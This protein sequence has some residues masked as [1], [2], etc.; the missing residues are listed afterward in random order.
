MFARYR[1]SA[2]ATP[3]TPA[4]TPADTQAAKPAATPGTPP[5]AMARKIAHAQASAPDRASQALSPQSRLHAPGQSPGGQADGLDREVAAWMARSI[6]ATNGM[7]PRDRVL[8]RLPE[9]QLAG[10]LH[11]YRPPTLTLRGRLWHIDPAR[12]ARSTAVWFAQSM[13]HRSRVDRHRGDRSSP[14][15]AARA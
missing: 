3:V 1:K 13:H 4:A 2:S 10:Q 9:R 5:R 11:Q 12:G 7:D 6:D 14:G 8:P 15:A